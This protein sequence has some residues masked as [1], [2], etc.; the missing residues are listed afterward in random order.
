KQGALNNPLG[1][2][3]FRPKFESRPFEILNSA[4]L[5]GEFFGDREAVDGETAVVQPMVQKFTGKVVAGFREICLEWHAVCVWNLIADGCTGRCWCRLRFL[6][7]VFVLL[8]ILLVIRLLRVVIRFEV[9]GL[10]GSS[11][12]GDT[13]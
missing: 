13:W 2:G 1:A 3:M 5:L 10:G 8:V 7:V 12:S 11:S 9:I 6:V 4:A